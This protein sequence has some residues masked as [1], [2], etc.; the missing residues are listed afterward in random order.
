MNKS[1]TI[2]RIAIQQIIENLDETIAKLERSRALLLERF[3]DNYDAEHRLYI[4]MHEHEKNYYSEL[5]A[6][7]YSTADAYKEVV[8]YFGEGS[9]K[10]H[11]AVQLDLFKGCGG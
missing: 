7:G 1:D 5:I 8:N 3:A 4:D 2:D 6:K 9:Q 10:D 11:L